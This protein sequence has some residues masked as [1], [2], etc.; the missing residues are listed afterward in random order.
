MQRKIVQE[1]MITDLEAAL[2]EIEKVKRAYVALTG[3]PLATQ[4]AYERQL[5]DAIAARRRFNRRPLDRISLLTALGRELGVAEHIECKINVAVESGSLLY[6]EG[7]D[8]Y[9]IAPETVGVLNDLTEAC[10]KGKRSI[11]R[12]LG[13]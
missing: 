4:I 9:Y 2:A 1:K 8:A 7:Q 12:G 13:I 3:L 11:Q 6:V 10:L 5:A